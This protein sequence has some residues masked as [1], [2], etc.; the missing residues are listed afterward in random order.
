VPALLSSFMSEVGNMYEQFSLL[1]TEQASEKS[2]QITLS[3]QVCSHETKAFI[4]R[5]EPI[6][7]SL[8]SMNEMG[9]WV[10][11]N[12]TTIVHWVCTPVR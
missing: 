8:H 5:M 1:S 12:A 2:V 4:D 6:Y 3:F 11:V 9:R 10:G 7:C